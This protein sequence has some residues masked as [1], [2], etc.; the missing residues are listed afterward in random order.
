VSNTN[1]VMEF[2]AKWE[3]QDVEGIISSFSDNP[4]Y[5]NIPMAPLTT[6]ESIRGFVEPFL[7]AVTK[8]E[9][10][11]LFIA[12]DENGAVLTER[13]DNFEFGDKLVSVPIMGTFEFEGDKLVRWRD[14]F[15]LAEFERQMAALQVP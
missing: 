12:E 7:G 10:K 14:Y 8:V 13:V 1:K 5:H 2:I 11:V 9:W 3:A 15:D 6:K 4:F